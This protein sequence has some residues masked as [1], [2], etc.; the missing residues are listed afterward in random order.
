ML[1]VL[2][3]RRLGAIAILIRPQ[4]HALPWCLGLRLGRRSLGLVLLSRALSRV[5]IGWVLSLVLRLRRLRV[6]LLAVRLPVLLHEL[7]ARC[8][9]VLR[10]RLLLWRSPRVVLSCCLAVLLA[11]AVLR[12]RLV[13]LLL[14][15]LLIITGLRIVLARLRS[16]Q[17]WL[18][19]VLTWLRIA[20]AWLRVDLTRMRTYWSRWGLVGAILIA[21]AVLLTRWHVQRSLQVRHILL[22]VQALC[23]LV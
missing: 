2:L 19:G 8:S 18:G 15:V 10:S 9:R 3:A 4:V 7:L 11:V 12:W 6:V 17:T 22:S 5:R 1:A 23:D 21:L 16:A 13:V 20:Q 14:A